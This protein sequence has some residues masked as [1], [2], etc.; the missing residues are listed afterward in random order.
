MWIHANQLL[1]LKLLA[2][3]AGIY[4]HMLL[5]VSAAYNNHCG[6][7]RS[8]LTLGRQ[9]FWKSK[10]QRGKE[11]YAKACSCNCT[12]VHDNNRAAYMRN[13]NSMK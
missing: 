10:K 3:V 8:V 7:L 11:A 4:L 1:N 6:S 13:Q 9:P 2:D 12:Q 5:A